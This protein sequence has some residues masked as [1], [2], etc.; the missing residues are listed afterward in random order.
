MADVIIWGGKGQAKV[1]RPIL[2]DDGHRLVAVYDRN[3][4]VAVPFADVPFI[5]TE[6]E[7]WK[8]LS[9]RSDSKLGFVLAIGGENGRER[10][11]LA[12]QLEQAGLFALTAIHRRAWVADSVQIAKGCQILALAAVCVEARLG[13][14][15]IVNTGASVDHECVLGEGVH[16]MP[17]ATLTGCVVVED[18]ATIG[19][20]ATI[21]PHVRIGS[22]AMVGAGAVVTDDVPSGARI[23][24]V[25]AR[26]L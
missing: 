8:W 20:N 7:F 9:S 2:E 24:G 23:V 3:N 25:P 1:L 22:R 21:L 17:G 13:R 10:C 19:S 16:I 5:T 4:L 15:S 12:D 14:Q 26:P 6:A 11:R 18:Y